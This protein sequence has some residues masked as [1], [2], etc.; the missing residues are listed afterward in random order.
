MDFNNAFLNGG[1]D[2]EIYIEQFDG[3]RD[4]EH[5]DGVQANEELVRVETGAPYLERDA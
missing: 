3:F 5:P 2:K 4:K 1:I